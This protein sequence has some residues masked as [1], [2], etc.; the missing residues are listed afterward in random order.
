M[1]KLLNNL[2]CDIDTFHC[3]MTA[4]Q[5]A[6]SYFDL[7]CVKLLLK[8]KANI[9]ATDINSNTPLHYAVNDCKKNIVTYLL[10]SGANSQSKNRL[11]VSPL[12]LA[13][14]M[15]NYDIIEE[16]L[17]WNADICTIKYNRQNQKIIDFIQFIKKREEIW[18]MW[19]LD[20]F[21]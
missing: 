13:C 1:E 19:F 11:G 7:S 12:I 5:F 14:N 17:I 20:F 15:E 3:G 9:N 16:L 2:N 6:I 4:L 18:A 21:V 10:K 8:Y